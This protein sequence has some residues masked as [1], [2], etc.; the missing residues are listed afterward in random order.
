M[1]KSPK[2]YNETQVLKLL[3]SAVNDA[4]SQR[5]FARQHG[6]TDEFLSMVLSQ[7][8]PVSERIAATLGLT[9]ITEFEFKEVE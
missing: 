1:V 8:K 6:L 4:G 2:R 5:A 9:R 7:R 3:R